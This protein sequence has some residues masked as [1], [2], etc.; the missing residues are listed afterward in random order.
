LADEDQPVP[1]SFNPPVGGSLAAV[2]VADVAY[3]E[4]CI[5]IEGVVSP[6]GQGGWQGREA[7]YDVHCFAFAG[8]R[9]PGEALVERELTLL[10]PV[11]PSRGGQNHEENIFERFPPYSIQRLGVL[12]S[13][14]QTRAV[15]EQALPMDEADQELLLFSD[16]LR[17]PVVIS[18]ERF[19]DLAL[20]P[21]VNWFE[22]KADWNGKTIDIYFETDEEEGIGDAIK[23]AE[24]LWSEQAA[25]KC[26][27]D[28]FAVKELLALKNEAWL[29]EGEAELTAH[30]FQA[31]MNLVSITVGG[32][33]RFE[34]WHED[35]DLFWGHSIQISGNLKDGVTDANIPG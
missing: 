10:R 5:V 35:G 32:G 21:K 17:Q 11:P 24:R 12:L 7:G 20:N 2:D 30:D 18:T 6:R 9:R 23:S 29:S 19:G 14:D 34:F 31:R 8:W 4:R 15:V 16:R 1:P 26:K 22:G 27:V 33:G 28:D 25:W 13:K 3:D